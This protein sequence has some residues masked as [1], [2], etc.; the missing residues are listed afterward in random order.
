MAEQQV[1]GKKWNIPRG[2]AAKKNTVI[3]SMTGRSW[4]YRKGLGHA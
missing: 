3:I 2:T 1:E 4:Q